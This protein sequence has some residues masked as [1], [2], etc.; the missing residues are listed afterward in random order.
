V[1]GTR[2]TRRRLIGASAATGVGA[3]LLGPR[4]VAPAAAQT[5]GGETLSADVVV[6]GAGLAGLVAA[7]RVRQAGKSVVVLEARDRVGGRVLNREV[8]GG[9]V[10][11]AGATF[12]GPTQNHVLALCDELGVE[13]FETYN[14]GKHV[15]IDE[16]GKRSTYSDTTPTGMAPPDPLILPDV[17]QTVGRIN[18]MARRV[19][20]DKPWTAPDARAWD[21][22]TLQSWFDQNLVTDR[23]RRFLA[24][25]L[26][27]IF[28]TEPRNMSLLFFVWYVAGSGDERTPGTFE[29]FVSTR[30]G[31]H[32]WRLV[33]GSQLLATGLADR[34]PAG[35]LVLG[36]PV[37]SIVQTDGGVQVRSDGA[38]VDAERAIVAIPPTLAG[39]IDYDPLLPFERDA[40][41][42]RFPQG[43]EVKVAC[44]YS[45][46]FWRDEGLTGTALH[47][48]GP[49][50]VAF[51]DSPPDSDPGVLFGYVAADYLPA[52]SALAPAARRKAVIDDFVKFFGPRASGAT[53]YLES[54]WSTEEWTR[55]CPLGV[56]APGTLI[57]FG[58]HM[59]E[60]VGRIHWAGAETSTYWFGYMDGAV[61]SGKRAADEVLG[62]L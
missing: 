11:E 5:T 48:G 21:S 58:T 20:V 62:E 26:R 27:T 33:G 61:R 25:P 4:G 15:Y 24:T 52:W 38:T 51:D 60:P 43:N 30:N 50:T 57:G 14:T 46:P 16:N 44:A 49:V 17:I 37:R 29:R 32:Q 54:N 40:L 39:R 3:T 19:P 31:A 55:G 53:A 12:V 10:T 59:R 22:Q 7:D 41:T 35:S 34:L 56:P 2:I 36:S 23:A 18:E 28:G 9:D 13:R 42:Q 6:V 45:Q 47:V 1:K 8:P